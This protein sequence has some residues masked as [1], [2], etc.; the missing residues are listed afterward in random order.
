MGHVSGCGQ[1]GGRGIRALSD[2]SRV[3]RHAD[4]LCYV[5]CDVFALGKGSEDGEWAVGN[6]PY[7]VTFPWGICR[8]TP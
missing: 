2:V 4:E 1:G 8:T 5:A 3:G 6:A 7:V